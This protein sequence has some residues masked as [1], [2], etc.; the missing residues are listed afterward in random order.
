MLKRLS[1]LDF[2]V[3]ARAELAFGAG[4]TVIS[5]ETGAGKSLLVDALGLLAGDRADSGVVRFGAERAE[6]AAEYDLGDA[7]SAK[8]WLAGES[9]DDG[10]ECLVRRVIRADGGSRAWINGRPATLGQLE[11]LAACLVE[12]HGQH[13]H[14]QLLQRD[15]QLDLLD[16]CGGLEAQ[17]RGVAEAARHWR[18]L[19]GSKRELLA[20][21]DLRERRDWLRDELAGLADALPEAELATLEAQHRRQQHA[22]GLLA[23][24]EQAL[25]ALD[26]DDGASLVALTGQVRALLARQ[27]EHEPRLADV[28]AL[29]DGVAIQLSEAAQS[30]HRILDDGDLD[31]ASLAE[32]DARLSRIHE[33]ARRH[34]VPA[35]GLVAH[36][37]ALAEELAGLDDAESKLQQIDRETAEA[38][39]RWCKAAANLSRGRRQAAQALSREVS[40]LMGELGMDGGTFTAELEPDSG[41]EPAEHGAERVEFLVAPNPGQPPRPLRKTASGGELSRIALAIEVAALGHDATPSMVFDEVDSGIGGAVAETVGSRLRALGARCQVLCVTHLPQVAAQGHAHYHVSKV[42]QDGQTLSQVHLL[43]A[44]TRA[45]E[46]ARMLGGREITATTREHARQM[47]SAVASA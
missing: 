27:A 7:P 45:E 9:L 36:R 23:A 29:L 33:L 10:D 32:T 11:A 3:V 20:R 5:G 41:S 13:A 47:L 1:L 30:L 14:Q 39:Q 16:A 37:Q 46:L 6:L 35:T 38:D 31:P 43:D 44:D 15:R 17:A 40:T 18:A 34:R 8:A 19:G 4:M 28:D 2:A 22:G 21:G 24:C 26:G 12:L 42:V 25:G